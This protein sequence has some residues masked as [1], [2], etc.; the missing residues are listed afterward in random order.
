MLRG[1]KNVWQS[2]ILGL[3]RH[4]TVDERRNV[5]LHLAVHQSVRSV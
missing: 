1:A 3:I 5:A 4:L 2:Q